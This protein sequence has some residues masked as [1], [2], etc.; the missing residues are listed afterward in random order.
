LKELNTIIS[1]FEEVKKVPTEGV[2][3]LV[4]LMEGKTMTLREEWTSE[5]N[6]GTRN[7]EE[8][9]AGDDKELLKTELLLMNAKNKEGNYFTIPKVIE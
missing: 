4:T 7:D 2:V 5:E 3:P 1:F 9:S 8:K 6:V